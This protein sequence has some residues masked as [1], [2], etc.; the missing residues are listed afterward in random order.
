[1]STIAAVAAKV[2]T[3]EDPRDLM[4]VFPPELMR[5]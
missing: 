3:I 2:A 1:M 4:R 5:M